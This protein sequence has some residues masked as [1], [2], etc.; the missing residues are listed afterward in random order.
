MIRL[1]FPTSQKAWEGLNE[2]FITQFYHD[3]DIKKYLLNGAELSINDVFVVIEN[4]WVDPEFDFGSLCDY[5]MQKWAT[6]VRNYVSKKELNM[7][8]YKVNTREDKKQ[9]KYTESILFTNS[10][11]NGKGCLLSATFI[12]RKEGRIISCVI[13]A[14]EITKRLLLDLLLIREMGEYVYG[15]GVEFKVNLVIYNMYQ[16]AEFA[17]LYEMRNKISSFTK[18]VNEPYTKRVLDRLKYF[19][20]VAIEEVKYKVHQRCVRSLQKTKDGKPLSGNQGL[21]AK[22]LKFKKYLS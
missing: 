20:E 14:S 16:I 13:R 5:K 7:L 2:M 18:G 6:L 10:H 4:S 21:K 17:T 1:K 22:T 19:K 8:K 12:K 9:L 11:G 15:K 3:P